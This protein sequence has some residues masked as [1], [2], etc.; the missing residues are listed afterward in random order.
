MALADALRALAQAWPEL[1]PTIPAARQRAV[2]EQ[3]AALVHGAPWDASVIL[4]AALSDQP[5]GHPAWSAL[6]R[7][8]TRRASGDAAAGVALAAM[9]LRLVI[10]LT[11]TEEPADTPRAAEEAAEARIFEAPMREVGDRP[12]DGALALPREQR[13]LAPEFQFD[14]QGNVRPAV[15]TVNRIL[16]ADDDPWGSA[17]WWLF[18]HAALHAIPADEV[19]LGDVQR[20]IAAARAVGAS[21]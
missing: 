8:D 12:P 10:E 14:E 4:S 13:R 3:L 18:P 20:V 15:A 17:S 5:A 9:H 16:D 7:R 21:D 6:L 1:A 11:G 19:R 2:R